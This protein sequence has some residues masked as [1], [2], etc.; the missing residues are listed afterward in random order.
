MPPSRHP[1]VYTPAARPARSPGR[2][3]GGSVKETELRMA[4]SGG[5]SRNSPARDLDTT[6]ILP[7]QLLDSAGSPGWTPDA[8]RGNCDA[9][10]ARALTAGRGSRLTRVSESAVILESCLELAG[11]RLSAGKPS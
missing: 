2:L 1:P 6:G 7:G 11:T 9:G 5:S 10:G 8:G 4:P 3:R